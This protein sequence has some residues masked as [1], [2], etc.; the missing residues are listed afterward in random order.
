MKTRIT[1]GLLFAFFAVCLGVFLLTSDD[2]RSAGNAAISSV[3][4]WICL[5]G[6][7]ASA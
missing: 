4:A 6:L 3:S 7:E 5:K 2:P 1:F